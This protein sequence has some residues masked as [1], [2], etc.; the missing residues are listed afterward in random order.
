[1][2]KHQKVQELVTLAYK[3]TSE[4]FAKWIWMAH[5]PIVAAKVELLATRLNANVDIA[6][7]GAWLHDFGDVFVNR[8][9]NNYDEINSREVKKVLKNAGYSDEEIVQVIEEVIAPHSCKE[10]L[11]P[12]TIEGK[13]LATADA[14]AHLSTD[15]Y[16]QFAWK[17][18]PEGKNY[19]EFLKWASE[20]INRDFNN[21][22]FFDEVKEEVRV[23]YLALKEVFDSKNN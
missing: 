7:A 3:N 23:R 21:K 15:F 18:L 11:Y 19:D 5:V 13:I 16:L 14:Y 6:V 9:D 17:H 10:G 22:I 1:M 4:D 8:F 2:Q 12:S 20:K